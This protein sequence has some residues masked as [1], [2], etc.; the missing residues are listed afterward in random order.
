MTESCAQVA[1]SGERE[2]LN[3]RVLGSGPMVGI[4]APFCLRTREQRRVGR[5]TFLKSMPHRCPRMKLLKSARLGKTM[6]VVLYHLNMMYSVLSLGAFDFVS[7]TIPV[8]QPCPVHSGM[9]NSTL[10]LYCLVAS[11]FP[12]VVT[13]NSVSIC[14][15]SH[16]SEPLV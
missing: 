7:Q 10:G 12:I 8:A 5:P 3:P 11:S 6:C 13:T 15:V 14:P 16:D 9:F 1:Q 2:T 4:G